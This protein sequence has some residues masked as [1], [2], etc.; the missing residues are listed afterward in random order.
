MGT[1]SFEQLRGERKKL[2]LAGWDAPKGRPGQSPVVAPQTT[3]RQ[4]ETYYPGNDTPSRYLFGTKQEPFELEG[5]FRDQSGGVGYALRMTQFAE[6]FV[7]DKQQCQITWFENGG[8]VLAYLGTIEW[9]KPSYKSQAHIEWKC[10]VL[11]DENLNLA[12]QEAKQPDPVPFPDRLAAIKNSLQSTLSETR[13]GESVTHFPPSLDFGL[14]EFLDSVTNLVATPL[15]ALN[16]LANQLADMSKATMGSIKRAQASVHQLKTAVLNMQQTFASLKRDT[17]VVSDNANEDV[18]FFTMQTG[19]VAAC[20]NILKQANDWKRDLEKAE[21]GMIGGM[22]TAANNDTWELIA[23]RSLGD[24]GRAPDI[25][26][27]NGESGAP[28]PGT[29][30]LLPK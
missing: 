30:Y 24:A 20:G 8:P 29:T 28:V 11:V 25:Q 4:S 23:A 12:K 27:M 6:S 1:W 10:S 5:T 18:D 3:V 7:A 22:V 2:I 21:H 19:F 17:S 9:W 16:S 15:A 26:A 14:G 13:T